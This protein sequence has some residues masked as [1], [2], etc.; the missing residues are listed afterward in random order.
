MSWKAG[1]SRNLPIL[2][3]FCC[4]ESP[5]S[6]GVFTWFNDNY[7]ELK[8]LNPAMPILLRTGD[9][10]MP[11]ITTELDFSQNDLLTFMIQKQ[12]FRD[13]NGTVSEARME[14]AKA[15]LQTDWHELQR[16]RWASP[17]FDPMR[18]FIDEEE[19]DWR[20]TNAERAKDLEAY[21]VLKDA[22]DEQI[23]TFSSGPNDE[24]KKA[25][26]AL[27]MCQRVDLWGAG[28]SEVEAAV[29]HLSRLGQKFNSLETDFP[30]FITEYYPG[31]EEL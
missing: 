27:L 15:Y 18:P 8:Q 17:G 10:C 28:P 1:L 30:D 2:R 11:A 23:A 26:N 7:H 9:N 3:F 31:A 25:E 5:S 20:Y 24:Y 16:Q 6:R 22:V 14:A 29:K 19:P 21:F 12:L 13:E 4:N